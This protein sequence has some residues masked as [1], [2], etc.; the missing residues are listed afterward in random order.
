MPAD[1]NE[2]YLRYLADPTPLDTHITLLRQT[3]QYVLAIAQRDGHPDPE[4]AAQEIIIRVL[5]AIVRVKCDSYKSWVRMIA[6]NYLRDDARRRKR[7]VRA[8]QMDPDMDPHIA[9]CLDIARQPVRDFKSLPGK[10]R[11]IATLLALGDSRQ[12]IADALGCS[13]Q[14]IDRIVHDYIS[15]LKTA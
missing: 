11:K 12:Q 4:A 5:K 7:D 10:L 14:T 2:L 3:Q 9:Q 13:R 1:I 15:N 6:R 8:Q